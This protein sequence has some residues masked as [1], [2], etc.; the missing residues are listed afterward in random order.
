GP[1]AGHA[2]GLDQVGG[3]GGE[4]RPAKG[5]A[6]GRGGEVNEGHR[7]LGGQPLGG[8]NAIPG[9]LQPNIAEQQID[10]VLSK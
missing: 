5:G 8:F 7:P 4:Q 3:R 9:A 10:A 6:V 2:H 1:Q